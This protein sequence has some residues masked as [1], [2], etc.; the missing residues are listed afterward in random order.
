VPNFLPLV[1]ER[2]AR[3]RLNSLARVEGKNTDSKPTVLFLCTHN[4]GRS[5]LALGFFTQLA[6]EHA[7]AWSGG[8]C[9]ASRRAYEAIMSPFAR[10][11]MVNDATG[12]SACRMSLC[13][14]TLVTARWRT[15]ELP[16][17]GQ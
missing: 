8:A 15:W 2:F 9:S 17:G 6:G 5:Q 4:A 12:K 10:P 7:V 16:V 13:Q 11:S 3:Q 1:A 14:W